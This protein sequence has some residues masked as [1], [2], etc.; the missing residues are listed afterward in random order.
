[1]KDETF[2]SI[3]LD[4]SGS[5]GSIKNNVLG[6]FNNFVA[7]QKAAGDNALLT[8]VQFD[9][10]GIDIVH[11]SLPIKDV[12][13]LTE[14]FYQPRGGT[15]LLDALGQTII[16]TGETL[17]AIPE[18]DRPAQV[19]FV[20]LTDGLENASNR[21]SKKQIAEMVSHQES[22]YQWNFLYLGA[23]VDAFAEASE[24]GIA[25]YA[26]ANYAPS[27]VAGAMAAASHNLANYR[28][29]RRATDLRYS[30]EQRKE[31]MQDKNKPVKS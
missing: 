1:M 7:E 28:R 10:Q 13:V 2:I 12:P 15:P 26:A 20:I 19:V 29:S 16:R 3:V 11:E 14:E 31:M 24:M 18:P 30:P 4:R 22:V 5:M 27:S 21:F 6:G 25:S 23:N 8:L 17:K 9:T